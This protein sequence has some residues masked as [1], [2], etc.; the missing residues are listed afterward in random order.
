MGRELRSSSRLSAAASGCA[1]R[2]R[3]CWRVGST[4]RR[5]GARA[6]I[7]APRTGSPKRP[8]R[9]SVPRHARWRRRVHSTS[10]PQ[11]PMR[12]AP[13][14]CRRCRP[15]RSRARPG[16]IRNRNPRCWRPRL[17]RASRACGIA[18]A[19]C[20]PAPRR[21][22]WLGHVDC[23]RGGGRTNGPIPMARTGSKRA[24]PPTRGRGSAR[25]GDRTSTA[26][27]VTPAAPAAGSP[28]PPTPRTRWS[29]SRVRARASRYRSAR[30]STASRWHAATPRWGSVAR[31]AGSALSL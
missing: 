19:K 7:G 22:T 5:F 26:S 25:P 24:W 3:H 28:A 16:A 13:E 9:Q 30:W 11:R 8:A 18:A 4:R 21:T 10:F 2:R 17:R 14:S 12:S 1:R 6:G 15:Q 23:T 20:A 27:S 29:R 31:S